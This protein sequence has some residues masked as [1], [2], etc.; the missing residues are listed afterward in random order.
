MH[1]LMDFNMADMVPE[2]LIG[3]EERMLGS[4]LILKM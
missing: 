1:G 3:Y 4:E 2:L